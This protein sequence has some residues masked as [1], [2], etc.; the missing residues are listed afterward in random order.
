MEPSWTRLVTLA[1]TKTVVGGR[2]SEATARRRREHRMQQ[3]GGATTLGAT[4]PLLQIYTGR[5]RREGSGAHSVAAARTRL[6]GG[7]KRRAQRCSW[8]RTPARRRRAT[9]TALRLR[10]RLPGG[11]ERRA[12]RTALQRCARA[13]PAAASDAHSGARL[14]RRERTMR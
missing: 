12:A 8:A 11:G 13:C 7:G 6:P 9:R 4:G 10:A 5:R 1:H 2:T 14:P 3:Q